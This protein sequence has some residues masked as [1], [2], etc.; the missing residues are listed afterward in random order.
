MSR[1]II[2]MYHSISIP[3]RNE[4][5]RFI[6][7]PELFKRHIKFLVKEKYHFVSMKDIYAF[8]YNGVN[9]PDK[10]IVLTFDDGFEDNYINAY[11]ILK[12]YNIPATIFLVSHLVNQSSKWLSNKKK[13][14]T[15]K[16]IKEMEKN[17]IDFGGHTRFHSK[18]TDLH[19]EDVFYDLKECK[20]K[21]ESSIVNS[22]QSFA[23]PYGCYNLNI[24]NKVK[25]AGYSMACS[26][27]AGFN[28]KKTDVFNL[29][30]LD[31][32][33][34][35]SVSM[36][37]RKIKFGTNDSSIYLPLIYYYN[38]FKKYLKLKE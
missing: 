33:G 36:L 38:Q 13:L 25:F 24:V 31:I 37:K 20:F 22:V 6:C 21:I 27:R 5:P 28:N 12:K 34:Y 15:W 29:R 1:F 3:D 8:Y 19:L 7:K 35:D 10:S 32:S 18:L 9:L 17:K 4:T 11:P 2:L 26:T 30:R 23:Y 14:L 16:Q